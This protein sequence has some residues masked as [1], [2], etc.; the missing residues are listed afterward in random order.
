MKMV[1]AVKLKRAQSALMDCRP[2]SSAIRELFVEVLNEIDIADINHPLFQKRPERKILTFILSSD[3][4]LCGSLNANLFKFFEKELKEHD[5]KKDTSKNTSIAL[6]LIGKKAIEHY[7]KWKFPPSV[8]IVEKKQAAEI[9]PEGIADFSI[10]GY[11]KKEFDKVEFIFAEF[12]STL[13]QKPAKI[14]ILPFDTK[15]IMGEQKA[16]AQK[17]S[18][19]IFEPHPE[20]MMESLIKRFI[21]SQ[22]RRIVLEAQVS[23]HSARMIMM[24]QATRNADEMIEGLR[25]MMN[26][27]RQANITKE[28]SDITTGVEAMA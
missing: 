26:K 5:A 2:Y 21:I 27:V 4:G 11:L 19:F 17:R 3:Q 23:E 1:S 25:L 16:T 22:I 15:S 18:N 8:Q 7:K 9:T 14:A 24:D 20:Q 10:K 6:A 13:V 12:K 28:L